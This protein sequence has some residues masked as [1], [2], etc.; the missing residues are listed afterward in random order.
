MKLRI[1]QTLLDSIAIKGILVSVLI[2]QYWRKVLD[3]RRDKYARYMIMPLLAL[4][5]INYILTFC[6]HTE[7]Y[8]LRAL[9]LI[10]TIGLTINF[11]LKG[12][13]DP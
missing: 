5:Q 3:L 11:G 6:V 1:F 4:A 2:Y 12:I 9:I 8:I 7:P 13:R 10:L